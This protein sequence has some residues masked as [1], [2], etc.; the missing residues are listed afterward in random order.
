MAMCLTWRVR[1]LQLVLVPR[2]EVREAPQRIVR[3]LGLAA[4]RARCAA[5]RAWRAP[6]P[7]RR[8]RHRSVLLLLLLRQLQC[9][10]RR[11]ARQRRS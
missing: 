7:P 9:G 4:R 6:M 8:L 3:R 5:L 11:V 1:G 10:R 2:Q